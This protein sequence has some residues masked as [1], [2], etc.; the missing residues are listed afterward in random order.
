MPKFSRARS[1]VV[2]VAVAASLLATQVGTAGALT[3]LQAAKLVGPGATPGAFMG[4]NSAISGNTLVVG[5]QGNA[6]SAG[7]A[8]VF[9][10]SAGKWKESAKLLGSDTVAGDSFGN[11][12]AISG[13]TIVVGAQGH[14]GAIGAAYV[15]T[16]SGKTWTQRAELTVPG[17]S[18]YGQ[19]GWS[20]AISGTTI[21]VGAPNVEGAAFVFSEKT[22]NHWT[23]SKMLT[24]SDE[25]TGDGFGYQVAAEGSQLFVSSPY[26]GGGAGAVYVLTGGGSNWTQHQ[27]LRGKDTVSGDNFGIGELSVSGSE[28]LVGVP[29]RAAGAGA[30]YVFDEAA[31]KWSQAAELKA[32]DGAAGDHFGFGGAIAGSTIVV[33]AG[34]HAMKGSAYVFTGSK[35]KWTQQAEFTPKDAKAGDVFGR[36]VAL[37]VNGSAATAEVGA[38]N[39]NGVGAAYV[40][41]V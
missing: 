37:E 23:L 6:A 17:S 40:F 29:L 21:V 27:E 8:W 11:S 15:F 33:G 5:A 36:W 18:T 22:L 24:A 34:R 39:N 35:S 30:A 4:L 38:P 12:V 25:V 1:A 31:G 7:A 20:V 32:K 9:T 13:S 14:N 16:G 3:V 41:A 26:H 10:K 2:V 28:L 19:F